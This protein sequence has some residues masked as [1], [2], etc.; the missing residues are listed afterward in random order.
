MLCVTNKPFML[1]VILLSVVAPFKNLIQNFML[2]FVGNIL[3]RWLCPGSIVVK[4]T[5]HQPEVEGS[6]PPTGTAR[7]R[8]CFSHRCKS[9]CHCLSFSSCRS[10]FFFQNFLFFSS[11]KRNLQAKSNKTFFAV[12]SWRLLNNM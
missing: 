6:N 4:H 3:H 9:C 5:S 1:S 2:K 10:N 11:F 12:K 8:N 7:E